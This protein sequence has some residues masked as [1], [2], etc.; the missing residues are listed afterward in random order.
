MTPQSRIRRAFSKAHLLL[1]CLCLAKSRAIPTSTTDEPILL[2]DTCSGHPCIKNMCDSH[3]CIVTKIVSIDSREQDPPCPGNDCD[4]LD[5][6]GPFSPPAPN[7]AA[8]HSMS[9]PLQYPVF[10]AHFL[11]STARVSVEVEPRHRQPTSCPGAYCT[12]SATSSMPS[13][14]P[15]NT[16][17]S[18]SITNPLCYLVLVIHFLVSATRA[19]LTRAR[20]EIWGQDEGAKINDIAYGWRIAYHFSF[21]AAHP[22]PAD[23]TSAFYSKAAPSSPA[24][25]DLE[26]HENEPES[27]DPRTEPQLN[28]WVRDENGIMQC[29]CDKCPLDARPQFPTRVSAASPCSPP[30]LLRDLLALFFQWRR[31][32]FLAARDKDT[33]LV[34]GTTTKRISSS[35]MPVPAFHAQ[36]VRNLIPIDATSAASRSHSLPMRNALGLLLRW[37]SLLLS[38]LHTHAVIAQEKTNTIHI[39]SMT[40][41][42]H[43]LHLAAARN[44]QGSIPAQIAE[45]P[46]SWTEIS[47]SG[48]AVQMK[49]CWSPD[50]ASLLANNVPVCSSASSNRLSS[51]VQWLRQLLGPIKLGVLDMEKGSTRKQADLNRSPLET[52]TMVKVQHHRNGDGSLTLNLDLN[53]TD[54]GCRKNKTGQEGKNARE[55]LGL[56]SALV[57][58]WEK[59]RTALQAFN[60][61]PRLDEE[62]RMATICGWL[63]KGGKWVEVYRGDRMCI[64]QR[65]LVPDGK[66]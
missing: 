8:A 24:R 65:R 55:N 13:P 6:G 51:P 5:Q 61:W 20:L 35:T 30:F 9:N 17:A 32:D 1:L 34:E 4:P 62:S 25:F 23:R 43:S 54:A 14:S 15:S 56:G 33:V 59:A 41:P 27:R 16:V 47:S 19:G 28:C 60:S 49:C 31:L 40:T 50:A 58:V 18:R 37:P 36:S 39:P 42:P 11:M 53:L 52:P 64:G 63:Y 12:I 10:L 46:Q 3:P 48:V 26:R 45:L 66:L 7:S 2:E 38:S 21:V 29:A 22:A 44:P 57:A